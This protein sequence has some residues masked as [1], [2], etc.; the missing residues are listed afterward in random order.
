MRLRV[1]GPLDVVDDDGRAVALGGPKE[2]RLLAALAVHLGQPVPEARLCDALW[3]DEPPPT[4]TK[5]LQSYVSRV[6][7]A[8]G[9]GDDLRIESVESGYALHAAPGAADVHEVE[10]L[11]AAARDAAARGDLDTAGERYREADRCWRGPVLGELADEPF[12]L[13]EVARLEELRLGLVEER[14]EVELERG[15][16]TE[17]IGELEVLIARFPLRER[18]WAIR[19][20]ALYRAGRQADALRSYQELRRL[21]ADELGIDPS[22]ELRA[23]EDAVLRQAPELDRAKDEPAPPSGPSP[24]TAPSGVVTF[25][26]TDVEG[27]TR[28]WDLAPRSM[29]E[30]LRRHDA[31]LGVTIAEHGGT[32]LKQRGEGDSSFSVFARASQAAAAALAAQA[33][34]D[35]EPWPDA[36]ALRVRMAIHMGEATERDGDY[37]GPA[38]NRV[39]RLRAL[40]AGGEVLVSRAAAETL[41]DHDRDAWRLE[42]LGSRSLRGLSRPEHVYRLVDPSR[43]PRPTDGPAPGA[44]GAGSRVQV[45]L[46]LP[47]ALSGDGAPFVGRSGE[48]ARLREAWKAVVEGEARAVLVAGE[49][50]IGKTSLASELARLVHGDGAPV[51]Y[52]RCDEFVSVAYQPY[53][54]AVQALVDMATDDELVTDPRGAAELTRLVPALADRLADLP[55]PITGEPDTERLALFEAVAQLLSRRASAAPLLLVLDDLHWATAPTVLLLEHLL[56]RQIRSLL[57]VGTYRDTDLDAD[58]PL[59]PVLAEAWRWPNVSRV[60]VGGL[61]ASAV[62]E[63]LEL[64]SGAEIDPRGEELAKRISDEAGGNPFFVKE[65][66]RHLAET[67]VIREDGERWASDVDLSR[68]TLP[69]SVVDVLGRRLDRLTEQ[70]RRALTVAA[71]AGPD[72]DLALLE[73]AVGI[74]ADVLLDGIDA[75]ADAGLL[76]EGR[77]GFRFAHA[78]VRQAILAGLSTVRRQRW[79]RVL[80]EVLAA[81]PEGLRPVEALAHHWSEAAEADPA[82]RVTAARYGLAAAERAAGALAHEEA[83]AHIDRALDVLRGAPEPDL[84]VRCDLLLAAAAANFALVG[85]TDSCRRPALAAAADALGEG[86]PARVALAAE[87]AM[88]GLVMTYDTTRELEIVES[89]LQ[90][91][92]PEALTARLTAARALALL[93]AGRAGDQ[94]EASQAVQLARAAGDDTALIAALHAQSASLL[95]SPDLDRRL[96]VAGE[97]ATFQRQDAGAASRAALSST[98]VELYRAAALLAA[99]DL[100]AFEAQIAVLDELY[101]ATGDWELHYFSIAHR[102]TRAAVLGDLAELERCADEM[103]AH[104]AARPPDPALTAFEPVSDGSSIGNNSIRLYGAYQFILHRE[105][106]ML[107]GLLPLFRQAV[108]DDPSISAFGAALAI[109]EAELGLC[110]EARATFDRLLAGGLESLPRDQIWPLTIGALCEGCALV[111]A[112]E[113]APALRAEAEPFA[114]QIAAGA[115]ATIVFDLFDRCLGMLDVVE[116]RWDD[117][118]E[119]LEAAVAQAGRLEAPVFEA[120]ALAWSGLAHR[121]RGRPGDESVATDRFDAA[122]RIAR[123][124]GYAGLEASVTALGPCR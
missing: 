59:T 101:E 111:G 4:A 31:I 100:A 65:L 24:S 68:V 115:V 48:L 89:A 71:V 98:D 43:P 124:L 18:L 49:P 54:S 36:A 76:V 57:V 97:L 51:V 82:V 8:L 80:G 30:A 117:A 47:V 119:R 109:A 96:A 75:A 55:Q 103:I 34:F 22:P 13:S 87:L 9:A 45:D 93:G 94:E 10:S 38:V 70:A 120:R 104:D 116:E 108:V 6:R 61:S 32:L 1:L 86:D 16:H 122:A 28:L 91:P 123:D 84:S 39:A 3:G 20:V 44:V 5:T 73:S 81:R 27:S 78:L 33:A 90:L 37:Y 102:A 83:L 17:A 11:A 41:I 52:G 95:R 105:R 92:A 99:G 40:A 69:T 64:A 88:G 106:G 110:A 121:R 12:A 114:G 74:E 58:H 35:A 112:G 63:L 26:L 15:R 60:D 107:E 79:H 72:L 53:L 50:G 67:G 14:L 25:L 23:L 113:W 85:R 42:E 77:S 66:L 29:D 56:R 7:K 2:R 118:V 62:S 19:M 21:L 46:D